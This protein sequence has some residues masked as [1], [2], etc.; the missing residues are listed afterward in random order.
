MF[1]SS[2]H[3]IDFRELDTRRPLQVANVPWPIL[4]VIHSI[5]HRFQLFLTFAFKHLQPAFF[6]SLEV[7]LE[8]SVDHVVIFFGVDIIISKSFVQS[9]DFCQASGH[10]LQQHWIPQARELDGREAIRN[11]ILDAPHG[12]A[13]DLRSRVAQRLALVVVAS[14]AQRGTNSF[15]FIDGLHGFWELAILCFRSIVQDSSNIV[16]LQLSHPWHN[17]LAAFASTKVLEESLS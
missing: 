6:E 14:T 13:K 9:A 7:D 8:R 2:Y 17:A 10:P 16:F 15:L 1:A 3:F 11:G 4:I 5:K 12:H